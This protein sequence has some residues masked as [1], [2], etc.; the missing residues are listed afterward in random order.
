MNPPWLL[1]L[2]VAVA[3]CSRCTV[4]PSALPCVCV[5]EL[6]LLGVTAAGMMMPLTVDGW[7]CSLSHLF[8]LLVFSFLRL[9]HTHARKEVTT[10]R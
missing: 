9:T 4:L 2:V 3:V 10:K 8:T 5:R 1:L 7:R 6:L